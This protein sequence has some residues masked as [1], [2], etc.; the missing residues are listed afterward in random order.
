MNYT[1]GEWKVVSDPQGKFTDIF[2]EVG[3]PIAT[4]THFSKDR[5][6]D[7]ADAQLIAAAPALYE[8]LKSVMGMGTIVDS[9][10]KDMALKA[11]AKVEGK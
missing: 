5:T 3:M 4:I 7:L 8:A 10:E 6:Q 1:K 9:H 11:L 2:G